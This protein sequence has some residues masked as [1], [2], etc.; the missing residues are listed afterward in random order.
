MTDEEADLILGKLTLLW[1]GCLLGLR[2]FEERLLSPVNKLGVAS[3][4][5]ER[6]R[7]FGILEPTLRDIWALAKALERVEG[8]GKKL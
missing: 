2:A 5:A 4:W 7:E 3:F 6:L 1:P 8:R